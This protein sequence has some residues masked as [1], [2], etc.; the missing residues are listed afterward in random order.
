LAE[1]TIG[2]PGNRQGIVQHGLSCIFRRDGSGPANQHGNDLIRGFKVGVNGD[3]VIGNR[4]I[5]LG[6]RFNQLL[7]ATAPH[8]PRF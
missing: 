6:H 2:C 1:G 8:A 7:I 4:L 3:C 5:V